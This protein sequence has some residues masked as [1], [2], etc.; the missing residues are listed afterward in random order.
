MRQTKKISPDNWISSKVQSIHCVSLLT[1]SEVQLGLG[2][3]KYLNLKY[4]VISG[5][6]TLRQF[7]V[8]VQLEMNK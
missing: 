2:S 7:Y 1:S 5:I 3:L 6:L 4:E 8:H